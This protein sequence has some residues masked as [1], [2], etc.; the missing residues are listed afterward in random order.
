MVNHG[1]M[2]P[3]NCPRCDARLVVEQDYR[4]C[5]VCGYIREHTDRMPNPSLGDWQPTGLYRRDQ[6]LFEGRAPLWRQPTKCTWTG[7]LSINARRYLRPTPC[8]YHEDGVQCDRPLHS[9]YIWCYRHYVSILMEFGGSVQIPTW[10]NMAL[11]IRLGWIT[12]R[13]LWDGDHAIA[14]SVQYQRIDDTEPHLYRTA[15]P[16]INAMFK[17]HEGRKLYHLEDALDVSGFV[18]GD[19]P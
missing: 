10:R 6:P 7:I 15:I 19:K 4:W 16:H 13:Y 18:I 3:F 2:I 12:V 17:Q 1:E 11:P 5:V 14:Q 9:S 8:Q